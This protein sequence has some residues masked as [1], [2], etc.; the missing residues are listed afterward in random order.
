MHKDQSTL[1]FSQPPAF[2]PSLRALY[3]ALCELIMDVQAHVCME[4]KSFESDYFPS[5]RCDLG[6]QLWI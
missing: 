6:S 1:P 3:E 2:D 4:D 5:M